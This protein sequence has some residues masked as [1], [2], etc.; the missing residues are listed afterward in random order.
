MSRRSLGVAGRVGLIA[1]LAASLAG[2]LDSSVPSAAPTTRITPEPTAG[3]TVYEL[4]SKVWYAGLVLTIDRVSATLD[5]R[6]GLVDV[7]VGLANPGPESAALSAT[8]VL[9][10]AGVRVEPTRESRIPD[11]PG[12]G[13]VAALLTYELQAIGSIDDA[14]I[15]IGADP[16]HVARVPLRQGAGDLV[17]FE[18]VALELTGTA[19]AS[20]LKLTLRGGELRWD[21]PDWWEELAGGL[22]A[23]TITYDA[24]YA[25]D[26]AGGFAFTAENVALRLPDGTIIGARRDGHSQSVELIGAHKT[27]K[28]LSSRFEIPTGLTGN[29]ALL[30]RNAGTEKTIAFAIGG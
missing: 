26:F 13:S 2:C 1:V 30:V 20:G 17:A 5:E 8:L 15:E 12:E 9:V 4:G 6:G 28:G 27:K 23:L 24:T 21:L 3:T 14:V 29:F 22:Q 25:G 16:L 7:L 19:T 11:I 10:V 18:P